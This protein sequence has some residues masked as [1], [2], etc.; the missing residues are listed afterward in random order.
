MIVYDCEIVNLIDCG[1]FE[2]IPNLNYA[3]GWKDFKGMGISVIGV[4]DYNEERYRVFLE[5]NLKEFQ[6][7]INKT[8]LIVGFNSISFDN[9]L[10]E[11]HG[12]KISDKKQFDIK[13]K[14]VESSGSR[15]RG[16]SLEDCSY[17]NFGTSKSNDAYM[18]PIL[19]QQGKKGEVI[20]YC[21]N[22]VKLTK[23]LFDKILTENSIIDPRTGESINIYLNKEK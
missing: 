23:E 12:I 4:Y 5:D 3:K 13:R 19:W 15:A 21:L 10:C 1:S 14:L 9:N 7:L 8:D 20:D 2:S 22:D 18:A 6:E 17:V 16:H 11:A